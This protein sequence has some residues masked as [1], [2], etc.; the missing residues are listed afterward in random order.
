VDV[1]VYREKGFQE[2]WFLIVPPD[3]EAWLPTPDVVA[4][5][6]HRMQIEQCFRDWK[7][8]LGLRGL[9]HRVQKPEPLL[10]RL[11]GFTLAYLLVFLLGRDPLAQRLRPFFEVARP[12]PR[13][14]TRKIL[15][16]LSIVLCLLADPR[17]STPAHQR[18]TQI[19]SRLANGRG[20][21]LLTAFSP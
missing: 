15:S 2:A 8:H 3:S 6:R 4:L 12:R 18:F 1:I 9:H 10:R 11:I 21:S 14:G 16:A 20:I 17:W 13:H 5:Y 7:S 19:L